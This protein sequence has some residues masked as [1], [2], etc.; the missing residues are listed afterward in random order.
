MPKNYQHTLSLVFAV[1]EI[2]ENPKILPNITLGFHIYDSHFNAKMT[3][4]N[5]LNLLFSQNR[6]V[7]NYLCDFQKNPVTVI[8]GINSEISLHMAIILGIYKIPQVTYSLLTPAISDKTQLSSLYRM[9][10]NE[11]LQYN[12]IVQLLLFFQWKWVGIIAKNDPKGQEFVQTLEQM[13]SKNGICI[14]FTATM[15]T[16][17]NIAEFDDLME[18]LEDLTIFLIQTRV[19]VCVVNA[20]EATFDLQFLVNM[21]ESNALTPISKVWVMTADWDFSST[22]LHRDLNIQAFH[23]T[24]SFAIHSNEVQEFPSFLQSLN[25]HSDGDGFIMTFWEQAFNCFFPDIGVSK[26]SKGHC[27]GEEKLENLP[28]PFFEMDMTSQSYSIYNA[29]LAVA[30]ALHALYYTHT[31]EGP[32]VGRENQKPAM[33]QYIQ[34][35]FHMEGRYSLLIDYCMSY[36][37][38]LSCIS[39]TTSSETVVFCLHSFRTKFIFSFSLSLS[40]FLSFIDYCIYIPLFLKGSF[41]AYS[42]L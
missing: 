28:G 41:A 20:D 16:E 9:V 35:I 8:G 25:P 21:A 17:K 19:N 36:Y 18:D 3:Y 4:K 11:A 42:I 14:A 1:K 2:N 22:V 37:G 34:V 12:G 31:K 26:E 7:L 29:V 10:P 27:T 32:M 30:H 6:I 33:P 40:F 39:I 38:V 5:T 13:F 24:L 15:P 23:G